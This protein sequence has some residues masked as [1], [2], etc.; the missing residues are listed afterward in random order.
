MLLLDYLNW[1]FRTDKL[2]SGKGTEPFTQQP[3]SQYQSCGCKSEV[4]CMQCQ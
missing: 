1:N 2:R 4:A 3:S